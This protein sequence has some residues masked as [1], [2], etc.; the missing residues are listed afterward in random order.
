MNKKLILMKYHVSKKTKDKTKTEFVY[1]VPSKSF[2]PFI[3]L[4]IIDYILVSRHSL[5][6]N[7]QN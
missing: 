7:E 5:K 6:I 1:S 2:F 4:N 3:E